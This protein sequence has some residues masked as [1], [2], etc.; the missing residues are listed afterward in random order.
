M[1]ARIVVLVGVVACNAESPAGFSIAS[2]T[3]VNSHTLDIEYSDVPDEAAAKTATNYSIPGLT[4]YTASSADDGTVRLTT[5]PQTDISYTLSVANVTRA[6]DAQ[7]IAGATKTFAGRS[8]FNLVSA[9]AVNGFTFTATFDA[10]PDPTQAI[11][12]RKWLIGSGAEDIYS[13]SSVTLT[14]DG[15]TVTFSNAPLDVNRSY[16]VW[17]QGVPRRSDGEPVAPPGPIYFRGI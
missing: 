6:S 2:V 15:K 11:D 7:P 12:K 5:S 1:L 16:S 13:L 10:A 9:A 4:V 3:V 17:V 8:T 14:L